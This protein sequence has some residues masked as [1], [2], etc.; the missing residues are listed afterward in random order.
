M[1]FVS[2]VGF[3]CHDISHGKIVLLVVVYCTTC[4]FLTGSVVYCFA[5]TLSRTSDCHSNQWCDTSK[6]VCISKRDNGQT[7]NRNEKCL[8]NRCVNRVCARAAQ[9]T[10]P[11]P[12]ARPTKRPTA[13]PTAP[14]PTARPTSRPTARPTNRPKPTARPT[15]KP[16]SRPTPPPTLAPGTTK[17]TTNSNCAQ[18]KIC[19]NGYCSAGLL[20]NDSPC[21]SNSQC[22]SGFCDTKLFEATNNPDLCKPKKASGVGC[23]QNFECISNIC[24]T[25]TYECKSAQTCS[26]DSNC[27]QGSYCDLA[28]TKTCMAKLANG[29]A[30]KSNNQCLSDFCDTKLFEATNNP[31]LCSA[32]KPVGESCQESYECV[33]NICDKTKYECT[34]KADLKGAW[35][36]NED[37]LSNICDVWSCPWGRCGTETCV[38]QNGAE[39][40]YCTRD[41]QCVSQRCRG[42]TGSKTCFP[43]AARLGIM[44]FF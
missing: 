32:K 5:G 30:C 39:G 15:A 12:T 6:H 19:I 24:D 41:T 26:S 13:R 10:T 33:S 25:T 20:A 17:C 35:L 8:S 11:R 38:P 27:P 37:C 23:E 29:G 22:Q 44:Y 40:V 3:V 43:R 34:T 7:C 4:R 21:T 31:D 42:P 9:G 14:R 2:F 36:A 16:T 1:H 18:G 28:G